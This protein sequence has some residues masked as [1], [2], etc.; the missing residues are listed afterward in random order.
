[1]SSERIV[2]LPPPPEAPAAFPPGARCP[3]CRS[4]RRG[5]LVDA[6][7]TV[8]VAHA[9]CFARWDL[10]EEAEALDVHLPAGVFPARPAAEPPAIRRCA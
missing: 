3:F 10:L 6:R 1:L 4:V 7:G 8:G 5:P 9:S 2:P